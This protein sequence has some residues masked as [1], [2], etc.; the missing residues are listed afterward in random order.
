MAGVP[1]ADVVLTNPTHYAVALA[2]KKGMDAPK[3]LAKGKNLVAQTIIRI[4]REH[5]IPIVQ[6]PP[7]ARALY[8]E[9]DLEETIPTNLYRAVAKVLAFIYQQR[10]Q[11][12]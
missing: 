5:H 2:Y 9:V 4:A 8:Q 11:R 12:V 10:K 7:L 6:N 3:V 1:K